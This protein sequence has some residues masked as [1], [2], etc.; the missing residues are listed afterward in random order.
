MNLT[1]VAGV[2]LIVGAAAISFQLLRTREVGAPEPAIAEGE[3]AELDGVGTDAG[4]G[5]SA[6][7]G[8]ESW[9][10]FDRVH[11][12]MTRAAD[13]RLREAGMLG[14]WSPGKVVAAKLAGAAVG[15]AFGLFL[16]MAN[17][18]GF[19]LILAVLFLLSGFL[20]VDLVLSRRAS[21]HRLAVEHSLPDVLDQLS[22]CVGAGLGL[23]AAMARV[24]STNP[25]DPLAAELDKV[26]RDLRLGV[27][28]V[29]ALQSLA[30]R[31]NLPELRTVVRAITQSDRAGVPLGR[32]LRVQ[33]EEA[34]E[35]RRVRAE[36]RAMKL[37]VKLVF[38]LV[39]CILPS[40]FVVI[41]G[42][43]VLRLLDS[44]LLQF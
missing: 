36:E 20:A 16:V 27:T 41:L 35:R 28:R 39:F 37:P 3:D 2:V 17:P 10:T 21:Q 5:Y 9:S 19:T 44:Q 32:I 22:I 1:L 18:S 40:L 42:P 24:A 7:A 12:S 31:V 8:P 34:R 29:E 23:E 25:H 11:S 30:D 14:V 26:L 33:A 43:A 38:P 13:Q 15:G 4:A 6:A